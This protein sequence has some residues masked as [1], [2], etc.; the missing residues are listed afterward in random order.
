MAARREASPFDPAP[1]AVRQ[2]LRFAAADDFAR[3]DR[4]RDLE[5]AVCAAAEHGRRLAIPPQWQRV[6]AE[7]ARLFA[8]PVE[9]GFLSP[10]EESQVLDR[11]TPALF[12]RMTI[13]TAK[14]IGQW[15]ATG[16]VL[17]CMVLT[18][19]VLLAGAGPVSLAVGSFTA[20]LYNELLRLHHA[21]RRNARIDED[22]YVGS[23][24][25]M[26]A[27]GLLSVV[28][29]SLADRFDNEGSR[30]WL[31]M[32]AAIAILMLTATLVTAVPRRR[33]PKGTSQ[34]WQP[35]DR[36]PP[37]PLGQSESD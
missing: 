37:Q 11:A 36:I 18:A 19:G 16:F 30:S 10:T 33:F 24:R 2:P 26:G 1:A 32:A 17:G 6:F 21:R 31:W 20:L 27:L 29:V 14:M 3:A 9:G 22:V 12:E 34:R 23:A 4:V 7:I 28:G 8:K 15:M 25:G 35:G 13:A 5:A